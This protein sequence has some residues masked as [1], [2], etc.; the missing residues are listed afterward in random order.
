[1]NPILPILV[2]ALF[3]GS[4]TASGIAGA[5]DGPPMKKDPSPAAW[6]TSR[7]KAHLVRLAPGQDLLFELRNWAKSRKIKAA[8][9]LSAVGS[10]KKVTL[11]F[12]N[13]PDASSRE[14]FFEIVSLTGMLDEQSLHLHASVSLPSGE[15][16][17]GH[18]TGENR[19]YTTLELSIAEYEDVQ[20]LREKDPTYGY[21]ELRIKKN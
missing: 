21:P 4:G 12:A 7:M 5:Q 6:E 10:L 20:F 8:S 14:G 18:L 16:I 13:Q 15:T 2:F 1:M 3:P 17:G 19:I 11:R 9:I